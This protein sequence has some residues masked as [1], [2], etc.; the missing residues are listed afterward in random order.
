MADDNQ[1][2]DAEA[3]AKAAAEAEA[4]AKADAEAAAEQGDDFDKDRAMQ[5]IKNLR[6][7]EK[8]AK[9]L[10]KELDAAQAKLKEEEDAKLSEQE[11]ALKRAE[12]AEAKIAAAEDKLRTANLLV[13]LADSGHGIVSAKAAAKLIEGVEY[14]D[15]G[16]PSN[17]DDI[18][19]AF[20]ESYP[21][22]VGEKPK[23]KPGDINAGGGSKQ[24]EGPKLTAEQLDMAGKLGMSPEEYAA[25]QTVSTPEEFQAAQARLKAGQSG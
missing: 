13:A 21:F 24:G 6:E 1:N 5:T 2:D 10:Q 15:D 14:D 12:A 16:K 20:I 9:K 7:Y 25:Y 11:K 4:K 3:A 23:A 19:P 18:L 22:L 8:Q 17:L